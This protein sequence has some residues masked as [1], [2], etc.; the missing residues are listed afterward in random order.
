MASWS[1]FKKLLIGINLQRVSVASTWLTDE[2][3]DGNNYVVMIEE[4]TETDDG[5]TVWP[6]RNMDGLIIRAQCCTKF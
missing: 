5:E 6:R 3:K 4:H 1:H 2:D